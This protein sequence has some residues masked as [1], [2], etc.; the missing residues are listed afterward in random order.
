MKIISDGRDLN[1]EKRQKSFYAEKQKLIAAYNL[2]KHNL[3]ST[4]ILSFKIL[5]L[6]LQHRGFDNL[7]LQTQN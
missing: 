1:K 4:P 2:E 6:W 3:L 5:K 7:Y